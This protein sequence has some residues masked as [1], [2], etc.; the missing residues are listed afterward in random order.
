[1]R[2]PSR[3]RDRSPVDEPRPTPTRAARPRRRALLNSRYLATIYFVLTGAQ[4]KAHKAQTMREIAR[5]ERT[6]QRAELAEL[7]AQVRAARAQRREAHAGARLTCREARA[8]VRRELKARRARILTELRDNARAQRA[9]AK[10]ACATAVASA[11][12]L[13]GI[14]EQARGRLRAEKTYRA[15]MRRIVRANKA[16]RKEVAPRRWARERASESDDEVRANIP[17]ELVPLWERIGRS[18]RGSAKQSRSEAFLHYA[19]EHPSEVLEGLE[20]KTEALVRELEARERSARRALRRAVPR[21][22]MR[23]RERAS[24]E[25]PF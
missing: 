12:G 23:E 13:A 18:I 24:G 3:I 19:E 5:E 8:R 6:K 2:R 17:P 20:D 9:A 15:E 10:Q 16:R 1:M 22:R 21:A 4:A 14:H 7:V 25:A 11:R